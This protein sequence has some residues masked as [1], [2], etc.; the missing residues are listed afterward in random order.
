MVVVGFGGGGGILLFRLCFTNK[1]EVR[2]PMLL[3]VLFS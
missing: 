1:T 2:G 3:A